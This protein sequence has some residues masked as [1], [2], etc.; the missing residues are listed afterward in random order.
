M[1]HANE[2]FALEHT[3]LSFPNYNQK[4]QLY[5]FQC[6]WSGEDDTVLKGKWIQSWL[7][8]SAIPLTNV[9]LLLGC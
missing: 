3:L 7:A 4:I 6:W 2:I 9:C 1:Q 5:Y 8:I